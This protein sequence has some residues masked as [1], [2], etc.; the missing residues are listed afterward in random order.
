ME[1]TDADLIK[2]AAE[3]LNPQ[4]L[5][6]GSWVADVGAAVEA[7]DGTVHTGASVGGYLSVCAEQSALSQMVSRTGPVLR[8]VVAVWADP[9]GGALHVLPPCG[10]CR[11]FLRVLR[12]EN[13]DAIVVL[14][15]DHRTTLRELLP[16]H[17][18]HAEQV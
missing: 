10:R 9:D 4:Q 2:R 15:P 16:V 18:W 3:A 17:G 11:E 6:D 13:L 14:G 7:G 8:R 5:A 1:T 12:Q